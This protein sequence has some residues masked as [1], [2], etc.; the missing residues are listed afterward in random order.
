MQNHVTYC[1]DKIDVRVTHTLRVLLLPRGR[2]S[3]L[4][5]RVYIVSYCV[6]SVSIFKETT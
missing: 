6:L 1:A 5:Y 2:C 4:L 3:I